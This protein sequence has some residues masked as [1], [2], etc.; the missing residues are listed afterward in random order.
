M[1]SRVAEGVI[2]NCGVVDFALERVAEGVIDSRGVIDF[3]V[4]DI[5]ADD[6][7]T[8]TPSTML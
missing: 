7:G 6:V 5:R 3:A 8:I 1:F 2:D 4:N